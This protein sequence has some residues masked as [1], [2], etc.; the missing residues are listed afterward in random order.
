[1]IVRHIIEDIESVF[2]SLPESQ[3]FDVAFA[4]YADDSSGNIEF[5]TIEAFHWDDDEEFFLVPSNKKGTPI[6][7]SLIFKALCLIK[8]KAQ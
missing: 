1:M 5:R 2:E 7:F 8:R 4:C 3:E 6:N